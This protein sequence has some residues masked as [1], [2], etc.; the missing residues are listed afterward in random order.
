MNGML[1]AKPIE[2]DEDGELQRL[3][4]RLRP[5]HLRQRLGMESEGRHPAF[6][7]GKGL[8]G[9]EKW[10]SF[11][12][13]VR[14]AL[15]ASLLYGIGRRNALNIQVTH[16]EVVIP[17]LPLAFDG[18]TLLQISDLHLDMNPDF[19]AALAATVAGLDYDV[20][21]L[22]GD[23]RYRTFGPAEAALAGLAQVR[24]RLKGEVYAVLGNHDSIRMLPAIE[25]MGIRLLLNESVALRRD[26]ARIHLAGI[27]DP[28]FFRVDNLED[29]CRDIPAEAISVLLAH[30]PEVYRQAAHAGFDLMLAGHTHGGQ[31]RLPGGLA[32]A[33]NADCPR[34]FCAGAWRHGTLQGYTSVGAGSSIVDVRLNCPP[35][36]TLH[37]LRRASSL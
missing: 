3:Q 25:D 5:L 10:L 16:N 22:T 2:L 4:A 7:Q 29:A 24:R 20:C 33:F 6:G 28:H 36:V 37:R 31:I 26:E 21:V 8:L 9:L 15:K 34:R 35:E 19:P 11:H 1:N 13:C 30:S 18:Y 23:Y 32:L 17:R 27:D 12:D 14:W